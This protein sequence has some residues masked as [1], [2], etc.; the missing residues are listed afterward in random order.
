MSISDR[1]TCQAILFDLDGVLVDS[2]KCIEFIWSRWAVQRG[3]DAAVILRAAHGR[4]TSETLREIMP[5]LDIESEV[6]T[7]DRMEEE[8]TGGI[9][10][11]PGAADL[12]RSLPA[13][14]WAIVTSGSSAVATLRMRIGGIPSPSVFITA[15]DVRHGKPSPEGYLTA[16]YKLGFDP[17][18][19]LVIEDTPAGVASGKDA[20]MKVIA[21]PGTYPPEKLS[22]ADMLAV[23]LSALQA[24]YVSPG[25]I[26]VS[27]ATP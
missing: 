11:I 3:L 4:R 13:E 23:S 1:L 18:Q 9:L 6:A 20:G 7:L 19:C 25:E 21:I 2:R 26:T 17:A 5:D 12:L 8:E 15:Q 24:R 22:G 10:P 27:S 14:R 16:A